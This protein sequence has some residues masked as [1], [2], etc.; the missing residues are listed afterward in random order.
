M[1]LPYENI[2]IIV[3]ITSQNIGIMFSV[4]FNIFAEIC[5]MP[6]ISIFLLANII[7]II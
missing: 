7:I 1:H 4:T 6:K 3:I 5:G 2:K